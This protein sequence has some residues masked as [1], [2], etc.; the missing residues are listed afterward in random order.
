MHRK[1]GV[2]LPPVHLM[3]FNNNRS[4][5]LWQNLRLYK[6]LFRKHF[7][8]RMHTA[9][10]TYHCIKD[11]ISLRL[12]TQVHTISHIKSPEYPF[13]VKTLWPHS[14]MILVMEAFL[15]LVVLGDL[16]LTSSCRPPTLKL[17]LYQM[18]VRRKRR[19]KTRF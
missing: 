15:T 6:Y 11:D 2:L 3:A 18:Q 12:L 5:C 9:G 7:I 4:P 1:A 14:A 13:P 19:R 10:E 16:G 8:N 17:C